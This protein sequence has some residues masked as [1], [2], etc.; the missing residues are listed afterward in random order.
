MSYPLRSP[1]LEAA[2]SAQNIS[3]N[4]HLVQGGSSAL[5]ECFFWPPNPNV[6]HERL[7]IRTSA[8]QSTQV[9]EVRVFLETSVLPEFATWLQGI[10]ALAPTST[11]RKEEQHFERAL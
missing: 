1:V 11:I 5:F 10:L 9:H 2:L 8:V 7:Y 6:A 4:A 3:A